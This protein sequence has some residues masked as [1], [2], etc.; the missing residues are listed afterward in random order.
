[1]AAQSGCGVSRLEYR[2][3]AEH[4]AYI[5]LQQHADALGLSLQQLINLQVVALYNLRHGLPTLHAV[6]WLG[7]L[8]TGPAPPAAPPETTN[9]AGAAALADEWL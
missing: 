7:P 5:E 1:M 2:Y 3:D 4:P 6:T 9:A 8:P